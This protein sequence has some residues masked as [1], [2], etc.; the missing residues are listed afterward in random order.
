MKIL[1]VIKKFQFDG[2]E[3]RIV[4]MKERYMSAHIVMQRAV[5]AYGFKMPISFN[6]RQT[7][8]SMIQQTLETLE[9]FKSG[10]ADMS[11][12]NLGEKLE[13]LLILHKLPR[14]VNMHKANQQLNQF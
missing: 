1:R 7:V 2:H 13:D 12:M 5:N 3:L 4:E 11:Q 10:G 9:S 8:K 6:H 14:S